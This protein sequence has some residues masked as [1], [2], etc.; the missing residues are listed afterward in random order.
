MSYL[1]EHWSAAADVQPSAPSGLCAHA[2]S[3]RLSPRKRLI[4]FVAQDGA[5]ARST[6]QTMHVEHKAPV[7]MLRARASRCGARRSSSGN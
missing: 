6:M 7:Y 5:R 2:R 4:V 3:T 1:R